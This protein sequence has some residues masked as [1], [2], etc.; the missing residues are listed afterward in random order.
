[1]VIDFILLEL[2][3]YLNRWDTE[4]TDEISGKMI[5]FF[6]IAHNIIVVKELHFQIL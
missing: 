6:V 4:L 1:M 5:V 2:G 3:S